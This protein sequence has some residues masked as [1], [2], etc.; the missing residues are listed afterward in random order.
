MNKV[1]IIGYIYPP[2]QTSSCP[3]EYSAELETSF[4]FE[5]IAA[6]A[7]AW[8]ANAIT[9]VDH[10]GYQEDNGTDVYEL[11]LSSEFD[12][13]DVVINTI[14]SLRDYIGQA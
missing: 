6:K 12:E 3:L 1:I 13:E 8:E 10:G 14:Y 4:D 5:T 11:T 9:G 7:E 2:D